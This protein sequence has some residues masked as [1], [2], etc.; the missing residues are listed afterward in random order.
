M[1]RNR[2]QPV[3]AGDIWDALTSDYGV[4]GSYAKLLED[5]LDAAITSRPA[6]SSYR[7]YAS[8][9]AAAT[10]TPPAKTLATLFTEVD[11]LLYTKVHVEFYDGAAWIVSGGS[12]DGTNVRDLVIFTDTA[13]SV[14]VVNSDGLAHKTQLTGV[15][16]A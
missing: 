6:F 2:L 14:R 4:T 9:A 11:K 3:L 10:Y 7:Y 1:G 5:Q 15:T 8:M 12:G 16:W 13:Q